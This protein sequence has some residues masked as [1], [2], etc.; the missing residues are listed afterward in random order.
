MQ[1][2][3]TP[4]KNIKMMGTVCV[5]QGECDCRS[6]PKAPVRSRR[7]LP[8][9]PDTASEVSGNDSDTLSLAAFDA[10]V[11][12][13]R[14]VSVAILKTSAARASMVLGKGMGAI[15][16]FVVNREMIVTNIC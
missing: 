11:E 5:H 12:A 6:P 16:N 2:K 4:P 9:V 14:L 13:L 1:K 10:W 8:S 7:S 3:I 15:L